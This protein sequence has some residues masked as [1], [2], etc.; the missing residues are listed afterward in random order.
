ME[1][2]LLARFEINDILIGEPGDSLIITDA[3]PVGNE[4]LEDVAGYCDIRNKRT[5]AI[6]EATWSDIPSDGPTM[7][8][9]IRG[10]NIAGQKFGNLKAIAPTAKRQG[11]HVVWH[12]ECDCGNSAFVTANNLKSGQTKSCG[13]SHKKLYPFTKHYFMTE[14]ITKAMILKGLETGIVQIIN[15]PQDGCISAQIGEHWFFF[16][17]MEDEDLPAKKYLETYDSDTIA[18]MITRTINCEPINGATEDDALEWLY[19]WHFLCEN[20]CG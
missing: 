13:C 4:T 6:F 18:E 20:G 11:Q 2:K 1:K 7:I 17:G 8:T 19:Y 10:S 15:N 16:T 5:G 12:C 14:Q 3:T 9:I